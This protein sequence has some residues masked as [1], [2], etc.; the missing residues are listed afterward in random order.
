MSDVLRTALDTIR[1]IGPRD[2][3]EIGVLAS[4]IY[5][6]LRLVRGTTAMALLR[7]AAILYV[8]LWLLVL[9]LD[10]A[11]LRWLLTI[12]LT[13]LA[14]A[15]VIIFQPEIRR[16]LEVVGRANVARLLSRPATEALID[17]IAQGCSAL[18][19]QRHGALIVIERDTG[20]EEYIATGKRVDAAVSKEILENIFFRNAPLHDGAIVV[21]GDRIVA[22]GCTLPLTEASMDGHIG[23]R[24][25]AGIGITE[26]TDAVSVVVSEETGDISIASNGRLVSKLDDARFRSLLASLLGQEGGPPTGGMRHTAALRRLGRGV[27]QEAAG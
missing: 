19:S 3:L 12:S 1:D 11:V 13:S 26:R 21:R 24:H 4:I 2:V 6:L 22:A 25:K 7:G 16:A 15:A 8:A 20:L 5:A 10:F 14:V 9:L 27:E 18:A 23:T 17:A